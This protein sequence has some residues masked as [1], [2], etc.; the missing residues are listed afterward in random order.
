MTK[1]RTPAT[2][3]DLITRLMTIDATAERKFIGTSQEMVRRRTDALRQLVADGASVAELA[4]A[5]LEMKSWAC[6]GS[7]RSIDWLD[8]QLDRLAAWLSA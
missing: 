8:L 1:T 5:A 4:A 7:M 6:L 3:I 2:S